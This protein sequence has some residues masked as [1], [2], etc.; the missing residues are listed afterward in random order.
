MTM[1][2]LADLKQQALQAFL[3]DLP[4]LYSE[5]PRQWVAYQ[6]DRQLGFADQKHLLYQSCM[7]QGLDREDF[8]VFCIEAQ[9]MEMTLGPVALD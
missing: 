8:V 1:Q 9:E 6:G 3:R 4:H 2:Q 5:R 7:A